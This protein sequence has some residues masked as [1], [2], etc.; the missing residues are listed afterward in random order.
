MN[1]HPEPFKGIL[2]RDAYLSFFGFQQAPL[3]V[4]AFQEV[5]CFALGVDLVP[6]INRHDDADFFAISIQDVLKFR[7]SVHG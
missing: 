2:Q 4:L 3:H 7:A 6:K 1:S 5:G